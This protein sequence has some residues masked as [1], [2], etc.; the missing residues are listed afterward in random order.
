LDQLLLL[1][2]YEFVGGLDRCHSDQAHIIRV[3]STL[4]P[5]PIVVDCVT[6]VLFE[7]LKGFFRVDNLIAVDAGVRLSLREMM[8]HVSSLSRILDRYV[9]EYL[10]G[11]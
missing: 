7:S 5:T 6:P 1:S 8:N 11:F 10:L 9:E 4:A 3:V 2:V